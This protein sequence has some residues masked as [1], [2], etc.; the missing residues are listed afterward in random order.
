MQAPSDQDLLRSELGEVV[1]AERKKQ[2]IKQAVL[3]GDIGIRREA[4]SGIENGKHMPRVR[5]LNALVQKLGLEWHPVMDKLDLSKPVRA[6]EEGT[7]GQALDRLQS[8]IYRRR[9]AKG[10]SLRALG[11]RLRMSAAQLSRIER[12]QVLHS[13]IFR[14]HPEDFACSREDRRIQVVDCRVSAFLRE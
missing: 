7:R 3:A 6:L 13:R 4:L 14:D 12:G 9:K 10:L 8:D 11:K 1:R 2:R 5:A